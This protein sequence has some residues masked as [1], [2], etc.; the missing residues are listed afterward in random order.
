MPA[1]LAKI[2]IHKPRQYIFHITDD[3]G[4]HWYG[5][6]YVL[7][8]LGGAWLLVRYAKAN[9]PRSLVPAD[10][11]WDL[12]I[13]LVLGVMIGGRLG[14][15]LL[16]Y[17]RAELAQDP[18]MLFKIW[19]GGMASHGGF[20][21]V[22]L[23]LAWFARRE[24]IPFLHVGDMVTSVAPLGLLFGR[25]ANYMNG[26]L[27]GKP[28]DGTWGVN[29][30]KTAGD[31]IARHPSQ[32]YEAALEGAVLFAFLQWRVWRTDAAKKQPG[33]I[34]GEFLALYAVARCVCEIFREP[35]E[36]VR[37]I[38]GLSRGTFYSIFIFA[39]GAAL[40]GYAIRSGRKR[41]A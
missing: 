31:S 28:T 27:W 5:L 25:I 37:L 20:I 4:P 11:V 24:K 35:D 36:G 15:F 40:I 17:E 9:P 3:F 10:K 21:G 12:I 22:T 6:A 23:A 32:L 33:R 18:L 38:M 2:W 39:A 8:F 7:G 13:A 34:A 1:L 30:M 41:N 29:F 19:K 16:G 14:Y 26:E